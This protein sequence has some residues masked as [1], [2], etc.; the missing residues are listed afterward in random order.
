ML[1]KEKK[2]RR[3]SLKK[4]RFTAEAVTV[5]RVWDEADQEYLPHTWGADEM[6]NEEAERRAIEHADAIESMRPM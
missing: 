4:R 1:S 5:W 3:M 2:P 6:E